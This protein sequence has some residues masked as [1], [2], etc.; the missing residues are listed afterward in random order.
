MMAFSSRQ[1]SDASARTTISTREDEEPRRSF[2][3]ANETDAFVRA[4]A[5]SS[6]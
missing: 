4:R 3:D 5:A 6:F 2:D 1:R